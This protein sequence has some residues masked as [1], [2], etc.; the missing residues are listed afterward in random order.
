MGF[1]LFPEVTRDPDPDLY[2]D[3]YADQY[4]NRLE[5]K[6]ATKGIR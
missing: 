1:G 6:H 4:N 5:G 2:T 3:L